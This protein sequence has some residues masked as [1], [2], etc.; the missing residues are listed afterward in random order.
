VTL[1]EAVF[2]QR[3]LAFGNFGVE[4]ASVMS[5]ACVL[6]TYLPIFQLLQLAPQVIHKNSLFYFVADHLLEAGIILVATFRHL[7]EKKG[8]V[9]CPKEFFLEKKSPKL[10]HFERKKVELAIFRSYV[11]VC[12]Q[13]IL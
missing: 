7:V 13:S 2:H 10:Q 9:N 11:L 12:R 6:P 5:D 4:E 8:A 3:P 1:Q